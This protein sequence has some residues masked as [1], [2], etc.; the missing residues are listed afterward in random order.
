MLHFCLLVRPKLWVTPPIVWLM[1]DLSLQEEKT[2]PYLG[3]QR[4]DVFFVVQ[5]AML[6]KTLQS[7]HSQ[8]LALNSSFNPDDFEVVRAGKEKL[9]NIEKRSQVWP[10]LLA[11]IESNTNPQVGGC[12]RCLPGTPYANEADTST[13]LQGYLYLMGLPGY[14]GTTNSGVSRV[15]CSYNAAIYLV[16]TVL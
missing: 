1:S 9:T 10:S 4:Y 13:I 16:N 6:N 7:I 11:Q 12:C 15:S 5:E 14:C 2:S 3:Q 8:I